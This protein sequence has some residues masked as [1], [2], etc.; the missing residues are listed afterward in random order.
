MS[1]HLDG[2]WDSVNYGARAYGSTRAIAL[3]DQKVSTRGGEPDK[4]LCNTVQDTIS[5]AKLRQG[6]RPH[7]RRSGTEPYL[8]NGKRTPVLGTIEHF[9]FGS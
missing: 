7:L 3:V 8:L 6:S 2:L 1:E 4:S 9:V 5:R